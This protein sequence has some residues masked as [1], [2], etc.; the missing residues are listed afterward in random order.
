MSRAMQAA[1]DLRRTPS[2]WMSPDLVWVLL[3]QA[4]ADDAA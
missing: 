3:A 4:R 2:R 1:Q